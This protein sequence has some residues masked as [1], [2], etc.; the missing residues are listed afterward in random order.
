MCRTVPGLQPH[1]GSSPEFDSG[2]S[3]LTDPG[4]PFGE[5]LRLAFN[6]DFDAAALD[7]S[8]EDVEARW[9]LAVLEPFYQR[10]DFGA[11]G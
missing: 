2:R 4:T 11:N 1:R 5:I 6:P 8:G 9:Q 10:Y 7:A 3:D